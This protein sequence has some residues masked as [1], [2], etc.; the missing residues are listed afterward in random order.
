MAVHPTLFNLAHN[1]CSATID[2]TCKETNGFE[3]TAI[4]ALLP[5]AL[6]LLL[7]VLMARVWLRFFLL[8]P[9]AGSHSRNQIRTKHAYHD[10]ICR[11]TSG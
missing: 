11:D 6:G 3:W 2:T 10:E 7:C 8:K 9:P 4:S 5:Q 1:P